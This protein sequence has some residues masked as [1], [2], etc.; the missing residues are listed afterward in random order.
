MTRAGRGPEFLNEFVGRIPKIEEVHFDRSERL[1]FYSILSAAD[2]H[3]SK[4]RRDRISSN[5]DSNTTKL[6]DVCDDSIR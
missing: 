4:K 1:L 2:Y 3:L 5:P 6:K